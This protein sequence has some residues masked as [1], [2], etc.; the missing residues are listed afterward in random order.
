M[1]PA[2]VAALWLRKKLDDAPAPCAGTPPPPEGHGYCLGICVVSVLRRSFFPGG[3]EL[4]VW[5][6]WF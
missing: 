2:H 6:M 1:G 5:K 4:P 3:Y